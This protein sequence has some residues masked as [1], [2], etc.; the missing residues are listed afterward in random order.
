MI[1]K[2]YNRAQRVARSLRA[3]PCLALVAA[4][5]LA[6]SRG[7]CGPALAGVLDRVVSFNIRAQPLAEAL[8]DFGSQAHVQ[9]MFAGDSAKGQMRTKALKGRYPCKVALAEL[10]TGSAL[11]F[12]ERGN[13]VEIVAKPTTEI[14]GSSP[15][16]TSV[17]PDPVDTNQSELGAIIVSANR[18]TQQPLSSVPEAIQVISQEDILAAGANNQASLQFFAPGLTV[19]DSGAQSY[20]Y[21]GGVAN[22]SGTGALI[23]EYLDDA[24]VTA[25]PALFNYNNLNLPLYDLSRVEVLHGP[26]GTLYGEGAAGG[27]LHYVTNQPDPGQFAFGIRNEDLFSAGGQPTVRIYPVINIPL[28]SG[29]AAIRIAGEYAHDGGWIDEPIA[30]LKGINSNNI[31]STRLEAIWLPTPRLSINLLQVFQNENGGANTGADSS[32]TY[33]PPFFLPIA[34]QVTKKQVVSHLKVAYNAPHVGSVSS[35]TTY[36][37]SSVIDNNYP[38][39]LVGF[40]PEGELNSLQE[41]ILNFSTYRYHHFTEEIRLHNRINVIGR[42]LQY[43][44]G[45]LY[46]QADASGF[47]SQSCGGPFAPDPVDPSIALTSNDEYSSLNSNPNLFCFPIDERLRS[48]A[49]AGFAHLSYRVTPNL[50]VEAGA[51]RFTQTQQFQ[52]NT[53]ASFT[54]PEFENLSGTFKSTDPEASITYRIPAHVNLYTA[55]KR[56]FRSGGFNG[57]GVPPFQPERV[58]W[59][60]GGLKTRDIPGFRLDAE[61]H[62]ARYSDYQI[63]GQATISTVNGQ[64]VA[65]SEFANAGTVHVKG[66]TVTVQWSPDWPVLHGLK[67][68]ATADYENSRFVKLT[69]ADTGEFVGDAVSLVPRYAYALSA[70]KDFEIREKPASV[71]LTYSQRPPVQV[72]FLQFGEFEKSDYVY[73]MNATASIQWTDAFSFGFLANNILND[74]AYVD[75]FVLDDLAGRTQPLT[76][77]VYFDLKD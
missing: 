70:G 63:F 74:H 56:G 24:D 17:R 54:D 62:F 58:D 16:A 45:V 50:T 48:S 41:L 61:V 15:G 43:V 46:K 27:A 72:N 34:P 9:I 33:T 68:A 42:P 51:R 14:H 12:V 37:R 76:V 11:Q 13:T 75:P 32:D 66:G 65:I 25:S 39:N 40:G 26:Q 44:V 35:N 10:L 8:L 3:S 21:I 38:E 64:P 60:E 77:G 55:W 47:G 53:N 18:Y 29:K 52:S 1:S 73:M 31:A 4:L 36:V 57:L 7:E 22:E 20:I 69:A 59:L 5:F 23:S 19:E 67:F 2:R 49:W 28:E 30:H 6:A 71:R